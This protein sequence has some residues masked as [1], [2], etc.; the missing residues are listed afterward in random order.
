MKDYT[1]MADASSK[2]VELLGDRVEW[3][4]QAR[5]DASYDGLKVS[6]LPDAV[7]RVNKAEQVGDVLRIANEYAIPVTTRGAG[8]SLTGGATPIAGGWVL[9]LSKL[10]HL[11]IDENNQLARCG[12]GVVVADLQS[13]GSRKWIVLSARS[14]LQEILYNWR[15]Y[16]L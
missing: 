6:F 9:D 15:E 4:E 1:A 10:N 14:I 3:G 5:E 16:R 2:L 7:I 11:E 13:L 8:S 12:P